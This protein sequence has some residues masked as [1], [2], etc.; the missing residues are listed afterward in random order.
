MR[1][2]KALSLLFGRGGIEAT[3]TYQEFWDSSCRVA[4][5]LKKNG[6]KRAD[7]IILM[8]KN[9]P[10]WPMIYFGILLAEAVAVPIDFEMPSAEVDRIVEKSEARLAIIHEDVD[11]TFEIE[12]AHVGDVFEAEPLTEW[13]QRNRKDDVASLFFTSGTT[14]DPKG[15]ML[16]HGNFTALLASLQGTFRSIR[17]I[18]S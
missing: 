13:E 1:E 7:R 18:V 11:C 10:A 17:R 3:Y 16:T 9:E 12:A 5:W 2:R 14:G 6:I 8:A 4:N 15:V